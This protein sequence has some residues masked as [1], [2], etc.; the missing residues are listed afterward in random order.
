MPK[1]SKPPKISIILPVYNVERFLDQTIESLTSQ[2]L[3]DIEIIIVN[4]GSTDGSL[5]IAKS[6]A[7]IDS[8]IRIFTQKNGGLSAARNTGLRHISAPYVM[9]CD[10]DDLFDPTMCEKMYHAI[11]SS[12]DIG[13]AACGIKM[14]YETHAEHSEADEKY[15]KIKFQGKTKITENVIKKTDTSVCDK[16]FKASIISDYHL[17]FPRG[18]NNEDYYFYNCYMSVISYVYFIK[19]QLYRYVR[20]GGSIMSNS[21]ECNQKSFDHYHVAEKLFTFYESHSLIASRR[22]LFWFQWT[23]SYWFS[24]THSSPE[25]RPLLKKEAKAFYERHFS[26][27]PPTSSVIRAGVKDIVVNSFVMK[28]IKKTK[29]IASIC[30]KK[31]LRIPRGVVRRIVRLFK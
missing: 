23:E 30:I 18:L 1:P 26:S 14:V 5:S 28:C 12:N 4:D 10:G 15:Y 11:T 31:I 8:R 7:R 2:T 20:R 29:H 13:L 25:Y 9:F 17:T 6:H 24:F 22:D 16:I 19:D 21:F 27:Y 3:S